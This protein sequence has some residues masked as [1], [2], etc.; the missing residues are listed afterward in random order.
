M[1]SVVCVCCVYGGGD[2]G[3]CRHCGNGSTSMASASTGF[4]I[5]A[6]KIQRVIICHRRHVI[7][8]IIERFIRG[9]GR[10]HHITLILHLALVL[11]RWCL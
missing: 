9:N 3:V 10:V 8:K 1:M 7:T 11:V 6:I 5:T 2:V 4:T